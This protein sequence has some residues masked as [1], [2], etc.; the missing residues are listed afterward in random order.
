[1]PEEGGNCLQG[2]LDR[3]IRS[4]GAQRSLQMDKPVSAASCLNTQA[5]PNLRC[6]LTKVAGIIDAL[7]HY[8]VKNA[9]GCMPAA[10]RMAGASAAGG[11]VFEVSCQSGASYLVHRADDGA[12]DTLSDCAGAALSGKCLLVKSAAHPGL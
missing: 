11:Y 1:M 7:Q 3:R 12:F 4:R 9:V 5:N 6:T 8:V 2:T 10:Q